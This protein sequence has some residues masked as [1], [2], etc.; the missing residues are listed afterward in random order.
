M[1]DALETVGL[2]METPQMAAVVDQIR[3]TVQRGS[4]FTEAITEHPKV[5]PA[6]YRAIIRSADFTGRLDKVLAQLTS[7]LERDMAARRQLRSALTYPIM[8]LVVATI[9][10]IAMTLFVLPKFSDLYR[11]LGAKLPLPTRMLLGFTDFVGD[12]WWAILLVV[13]VGI[14]IGIRSEEHTS[15]LQSH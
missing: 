10:V 8:V 12:F 3:A 4:G 14:G 15:E 11:G 1:I 6:Y 7:Y 5:F 2:Q 9:A 13:V